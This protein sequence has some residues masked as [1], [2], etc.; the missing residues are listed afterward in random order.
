MSY[1]KL[2]KSF[3]DSANVSIGDT[4]KVEKNKVFYEGMLLDRSED[5]DDGYIVLKLDS[6]YNLGVNILDAKIELIKKVKNLKFNLT[7]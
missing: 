5:S 1:K 7:H 2:A 3:L 4:V 6:G